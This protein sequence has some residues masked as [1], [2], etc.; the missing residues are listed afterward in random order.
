MP[1]SG[2]ERV[3][4]EEET[5]SQLARREENEA[6]QRAQW[7]HMRRSLA[8]EVSAIRDAP[9]V[10]QTVRDIPVLK[11]LEFEPVL[12]FVD[13]FHEY[14]AAGGMKTLATFIH[15]DMRAIVFRHR[16][17][18]KFMARPHTELDAEPLQDLCN[19]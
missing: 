9:S 3:E 5:A 2:E 18:A 16:D 17:A 15:R 14:R 11:R 8:E 19:S 13:T 7:E 4:S 10:V 1:P 12:H 6:A